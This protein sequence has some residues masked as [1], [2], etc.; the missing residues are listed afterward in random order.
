MQRLQYFFQWGNLHR[1]LIGVFVVIIVFFS[2]F[3]LVF[4]KSKSI[5]PKPPAAAPPTPTYV[6]DE[7][8]VKYKTGQTPDQMGEAQ[9]KAVQAVLDE[10]GVISQE[11]VYDSINPILKNYYRLKLKRGANVL[12]SKEIL[13]KLDAIQSAE[14]D[15]IYST[16]EVPNDPLFDT[17]QWDMKKINMEQAWDVAKG[18]TNIIIAIVDTGIDYHQIDLPT[19]IIKGMDYVNRDDDPMDDSGHGTHVAG[20]IGAITNNNIGISSVNQHAK[21]MAVKTMATDGL[22]NGSDVAQGIVY[23]TD[24]GAKIINLSLGVTIQCNN[25]A[26]SVINDAVQYALTKNVIVVAAAGNNN[27]DVAA[28]TPASC[29]GVIT[30][31]GT[32]MNDQKVQSSNYGSRIDINAPGENIVSTKSTI[33]NQLK[34]KCALI[35]ENYLACTGTS[36]A[37]PH[38]AGAIALLV[39]TNPSLNSKAI[40]D[41]LVQTADPLEGTLAPRMNVY[42]AL[43]TC[44]HVTPL[45]TQSATPTPNPSL[46]PSI[47][48]TQPITPTITSNR[49]CTFTVSP[50]HTGINNPLSLTISNCSSGSNQPTGTQNNK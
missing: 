44:G 38:V 42:K 5:F 4:L 43:I 19:D 14:P 34:S 27:M 50:N 17:Y 45:P 18:S 13:K 32:T 24:H 15:Y 11:K 12:K 1:L 36:M 23:A 40:R 22:G 3:F 41:C 2:A 48:I 16:Q 31:G 6:S 26:A 20:V 33:Y 37:S 25:P 39:A 47:T 49:S 8:I 9:K 46:V 7:I 28:F 30:V 29:D 10:G 21:L 35:Q